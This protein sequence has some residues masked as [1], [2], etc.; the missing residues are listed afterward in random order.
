MFIFALKEEDKTKSA[1]GPGIKIFYPQISTCSVEETGKLEG[2]E[3]EKEQE[4][5]PK[6]HAS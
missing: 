6:T 4:Q 1:S 2:G 5:D 3:E